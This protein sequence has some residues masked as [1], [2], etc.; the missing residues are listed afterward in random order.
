M[1]GTMRAAVMAGFGQP[2]RLVDV[3]RP[4]PGPGQ[5]LIKLQASGVCH[6]DVHIWKCESRPDVPPAP[7]ILGHESVGLVAGIGPGVTGWYLGERAGAAW[8]HG[9]LREM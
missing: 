6:S 9:Y 3:A 8:L 1:T 4:E 5:I 7:F 2:L